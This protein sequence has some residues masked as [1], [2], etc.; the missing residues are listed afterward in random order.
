M[1]MKRERPPHRDND[2]SC[3]EIV[4]A[5]RQFGLRTLFAGTT[6]VALAAWAAASC[7]SLYEIYGDVAS[8]AIPLL[9][10]FTF[11][12]T[13]PMLIVE[14]TR[15]WWYRSWVVIFVAFSLRQSVLVRRLAELRVEVAEVVRYV[16]A[17]E[18]E[19]GRF[20]ND[21]SQYEFQH[22]HL[23]DYIEYELTLP[24]AY[25]IRWHPVPI[26]GISHWYYGP[27]NGHYFEDD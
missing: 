18:A 22:P 13:T 15:R 4:N 27:G 16:D 23:A 8:K 20:P 5:P 25:A 3:I 21:L 19:Q 12:V 6:F 7:G 2:E 14:R 1:A 17:F 9:G 24:I 11:L 10:A 26:Y